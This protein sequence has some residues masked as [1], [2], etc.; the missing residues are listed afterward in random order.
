MAFFYINSTTL[1]DPPVV[2]WKLMFCRFNPPYQDYVVNVVKLLTLLQQIVFILLTLSV[3]I[4]I[5][6]LTRLLQK[7]MYIDM[8]GAQ[9]STRIWLQ[10][11]FY[12]RKR[13]NCQI[14]RIDSCSEG[15]CVYQISFFTFTGN[16]EE[17]LPAECNF[18]SL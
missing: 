6:T 10:T 5:C 9:S 8:F 16:T 7:I 13:L 11:K 17:L 12:P 1:R 2:S 15:L 14:S 18:L 4:F 3:P